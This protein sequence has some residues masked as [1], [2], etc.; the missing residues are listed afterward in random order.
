M[1]PFRPSHSLSLQG[2]GPLVLSSCGCLFQLQLSCRSSLPGPP[3]AAPDPCPHHRGPLPEYPPPLRPRWSS[4]SPRR[5]RSPPLAMA[6]A[7][8]A[9][10]D[11]Y[12]QPS[13]RQG[14]RC[15]AAR[16]PKWPQ[17]PP[18]GHAPPHPTFTCM[19]P[20]AQP[21]RTQLGSRRPG[22]KSQSCHHKPGALDAGSSLWG[23]WSAP[24]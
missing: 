17:G 20:K 13:S 18:P 24:R 21:E 6:P 4:L 9:C 2:L 16:G 8:L 23:P 1:T 19:F 11:L 15:P 22:F 14:Q 3:Q 10:P 5:P 12:I 7:G